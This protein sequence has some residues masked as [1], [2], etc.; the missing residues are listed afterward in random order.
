[1]L[2]KHKIL[3][4]DDVRYA[5]VDM[6]AE[7][8]DELRIKTLSVREQLE[9]EKIKEGKDAGQIVLGM[10]LRCC[11]GEDGKRLFEDKDVKDLQEKDTAAIFKVF[12]ACLD[13]NAIKED[14]LEE[15]AKN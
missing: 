5:I 1:M 11:V 4:A 9:Y 8:G 12:H 2:T 14:A 13:L 15:E 3:A 7:W 6:T 10:V